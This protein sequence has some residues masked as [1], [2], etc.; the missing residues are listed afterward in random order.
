MLVGCPS[1]FLSNI[2]FLSSKLKKWHHRLNKIKF[3]AF[4]HSDYPMIP[5]WHGFPSPPTIVK[6]YLKGCSR[7]ISAESR[8]FRSFQVHI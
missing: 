4:R 6:H 3:E 7:V 2:C 8:R 5:S 1:I